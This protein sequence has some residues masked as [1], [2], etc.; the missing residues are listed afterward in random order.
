METLTRELPEVL[1]DMDRLVEENFASD[2]FVSPETIDRETHERLQAVLHPKL[3]IPGDSPD[4]RLLQIES[5]PTQ[6]DPFV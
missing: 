4:T 2:L 6:T 1:D 5:K 3:V